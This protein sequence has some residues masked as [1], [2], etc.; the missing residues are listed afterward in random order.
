MNNFT[1]EE[2]MLKAI[3]DLNTQ[4]TPNY[5]GTAKKWDVIRTTLMRRFTGQTSSRTVS[6]SKYRQC[7][8]NAQ[9][10]LLIGH[11]KILTDRRLP[12]TSQ[13][14]RNLAEEIIGDSVGKNW[15][16][17]FVYRRRDV[18]IGRYL[19][20]IDN[21]RVKGEYKARIKEFYQLVSLL[22]KWL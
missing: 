20:N 11:I 13:M 21:S 18:L 4:L 5:S 2:R 14:V 15:V 8:T 19:K 3:E 22:N 17:D 10:E 12:P 7:L 16:G 9:E 6:N 1:K